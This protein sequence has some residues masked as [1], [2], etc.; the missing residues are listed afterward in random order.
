MNAICRISP[1]S[2]RPDD[3]RSPPP[4]ISRRENARHTGPMRPVRPNIPARIQR[5]SEIRQQLA[6]LWPCEPHRQQ[7]EIC[8]KLE[9]TSDD[10]REV[11]TSVRE[12]LR[13]QPHA[14][15]AFEAPVLP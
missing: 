12:Q 10:G 7:N 6:L 11:R 9:F 5:H 2:D 15:E 1:L 14:M 3:Q 8:F 13:L 4:S